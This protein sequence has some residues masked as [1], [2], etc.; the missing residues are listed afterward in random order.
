MSYFKHKVYGILFNLFKHTKID[1]KSVS[2]IIDSRESF[3]GNLDYIKKEF[4]KRGDYKFHFFYKDKL[5][6]GSFKKLAGSKYIF[7]NDNFFPLAFM[8]FKDENTIVQ[9][10]HA[11]GASKKFGGSVDIESRDILKKISENT[12]YLIVTSDKIK[13]YYSEAFQMPESKIKALGLP[14]MDYYFENHD[15]DKIKEGFLK[16]YNISQDKKIILYAPTFRDESKFNNVFDYLNLNKFN[17]VFSDE[18]VLAL[19]LHPKIKNFYQDDI[20]SRGQYVDVSD[21]ESEQE[22][23]L[24][25]DILITDYSSIM[26]EYAILNRPII[27]F[28]YDL[29]S[30]LANER[31]F[32]YDFKTTVP[33]PIVYTS[34]ELIDLIVNADFDKSKISGFVKTQFDEIDGQ[35]SKRVVDFLLK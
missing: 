25:S 28:T 2:F 35:S 15:L 5:S 8:N 4:E 16:R 10:W 1:E 14:R 30:Y 29:D 24:I 31:G 13:G 33:G 9:L 26:I 7:L 17:E 19:R 23:M 21:F 27:F 20:S 34:D 32:Y 22:L 18:Y 11:P 12:D 6:F 3:K